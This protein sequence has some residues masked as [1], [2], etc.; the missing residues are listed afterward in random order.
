MDGGRVHLPVKWRAKATAI[1]VN[2]RGMRPP[3]HI[4]HILHG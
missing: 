2:V 4:T 3:L 1:D